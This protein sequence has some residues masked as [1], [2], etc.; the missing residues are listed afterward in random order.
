MLAA[1]AGSALGLAAGAR[2]AARARAA[3]TRDSEGSGKELPSRERTSG[4]AASGSQLRRVERARAEQAEVEA[5]LR[6]LEATLRDV[7]DGAGADEAIFWSWV[8]SRD[9]LSPTAW[10]TVEAS[11]PQFF[12]AGSWAPLTRWTAEQRMIQREELDGV[13]RF[14]SVPVA[15]GERLLGVLSLSRESGLALPAADEQEWLARQGRQFATLLELCEVRREYGRHMRQS[16][17]LLE[18]V[19]H[20]QAH[21]AP[22]ALARAICE[23]ASEVT[24]ARWAALVR[25]RV[26]TNAGVV[27]YATH[28]FGVEPGLDVVRDSVVSSVCREALPLVQEDSS[29]RDPGEWMFGPGERLPVLG[30][31][32][33]VPL[34]DG[35]AP[36]GALVIGAPEPGA[37][38]HD[39][40]QHIALLAAASASSL[41]R[42]WDLEEI[43]QRA[44]T[45]AL[46]GLA[47]RRSFDDH[48]HR[49]LSET[50]R[51]GGSAAL[52][53]VDIDHFKTVNDGYGHDAGDAVLRAVARTLK[54]GVRTVDLCARYGGEEIAI[55]LPHT[56]DLGAHELA[57]RLRHAIE[58]RT[59]RHG[60]DEIRVTA[61]FGVASYP[62]GART[63]DAL[64]PAA[65]RALYEAKHDGRNC[66][67]RAQRTAKPTKT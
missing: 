24:T 61:S 4:H 26:E 25:W 11:R 2:L 43:N 45:D 15:H 53:L 51:F 65:D 60:G 37:I 36:I 18:A 6:L 21:R 35:E 48:L 30:S 64:F 8:E 63:R 50:D 23:T 44:L 17:A 67:R 12:R 47:N 42:D 29:A 13:V 55:L 22:G 34:Y 62:G 3:R 41:A 52:I 16:Q 1:L 7:R 38:G 19:G 28:G 20:V 46:T 5:E 33:V 54:D 40:A 27:Q 58:S 31:R 32:A 59:V 14:A 66:V 57:E 9:S 49:V 39:D 56:D 10:S